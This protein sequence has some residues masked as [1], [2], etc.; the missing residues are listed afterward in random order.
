[1][2]IAVCKRWIEVHQLEQVLNTL[3]RLFS[4]RDLVHKKRLANNIGN[5]HTRIE[6]R[7]RV[8]EDHLHLTAHPAQFFAF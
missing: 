5:S 3:L 4:C 2:W 7:I 8:L 6:A 1:M